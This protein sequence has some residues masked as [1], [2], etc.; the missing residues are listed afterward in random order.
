MNA[1]KPQQA[2]DEQVGVLV[3]E[4]VHRQC[5]VLKTSEALPAWAGATFGLLVLEN[6]KARLSK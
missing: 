3:T 1:E 4:I 5:A 2:R 6:H